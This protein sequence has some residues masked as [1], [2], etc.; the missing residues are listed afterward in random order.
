M[1]TSIASS[2]RL[3]FLAAASALLLGCGLAETTAVAASEA[4]TAAEQ[5]K[6]GKELEDKVRRDV[7]AA[8]QTAV[9]E[10]AKAEAAAAWSQWEGDTISIRGP[11]ARPSKFNEIDFAIAF[12]R[13]ECHFF[14]NHGFFPEE[15]WI[16]KNVAKIRDIPGWIVQ[17]RFDA[18]TDFDAA[19]LIYR[20]CRRAGITPRGMIDCMIAA[21]AWRRGASLLCCDVDLE[22]VA[23][24]IGIDLDEASVRT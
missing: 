5:A 16:L 8:Q 23:T 11:E 17:G 2:L 6:Q 12:A 13:I 4:A 14:A 24:V 10:R 9:D 18:S 15:G 7:A 1:N 22:R 19:A 3:A 20:R 21:V